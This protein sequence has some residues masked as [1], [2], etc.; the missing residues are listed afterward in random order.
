ML[1]TLALPLTLALLPLGGCVVVSDFYEGCFDSQ[2]CVAGATC[3]TV[4]NPTN[5][6]PDSFCSASCVDD[7]DCPVDVATGY[8]G[9]C[10]SVESGSEIDDLVVPICY[11]RCDFDTDCPL[12]FGCFDTTAA[13]PVCLPL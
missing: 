10:F 2:D 13:D 6:I 8:G 5:G 12:G 11:A 1:R 3:F 4:T 9:A 7:L